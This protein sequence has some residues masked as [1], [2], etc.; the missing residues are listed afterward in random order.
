MCWQK[1]YHL[2]EVGNYE[3]IYK[4]NI[5]IYTYT[6]FG[7]TIQ[8]PSAIHIEGTATMK[9]SIQARLVNAVENNPDV[10]DAVSDAVILSL[11]SITITYSSSLKK[12]GTPPTP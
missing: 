6:V 12:Y 5:Y 2:T 4:I 8:S 10:S 9:F 1:D 7:L 3:Q 11:S